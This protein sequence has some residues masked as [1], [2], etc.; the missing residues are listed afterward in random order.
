MRYP[1]ST[2]EEQRLGTCNVAIQT[3]VLK[4]IDRW[5]IAIIFG[6]RN[7]ADQDKAFAEGKTKLKFPNSKHNSLPS[8]A[9]DMVPVELKDKRET[10]DWNDRERMHLFAG[11]VLAV[12]DQMGIKLRWGGDWDGDTE[13]KDNSFDDLVHFELIDAVEV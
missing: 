1:L 4:V 10:I 7:K 2:I 11:Y 6:Y 13:V 8:M 3:L 9:I 5:N 12:A